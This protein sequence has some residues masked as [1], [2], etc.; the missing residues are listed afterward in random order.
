VSRTPERE[1]R[2]GVG[3]FLSRRPQH[4]WPEGVVHHGARLL[5]VVGLA[6]LVTLLFPPESRL[7]VAPYQV[8]M[9]SNE[10]VIARVPFAVP[11]SQAELARARRDARAAVPPTFNLRAEAADSTMARLDRFFERLDS[12]ATAADSAEAVRRILERASISPTEQQIELL[13]GE[14]GRQQLRGTAMQ[15]AREILPL[16]VAPAG[17]LE[18]LSTDRVTVRTADGEAEGE[19]SV[20]RDEV[21]SSQDFYVQAVNRLPD[22]SSPDLQDVLRVIMIQHIE[23]TYELNVPAT[24]LDRDQAAR[25][26]QT[27]SQ[28]VLEGEAIV[29]ANE[30]ITPET[31]ARL[32]AYQAQLRA[33]GL[34]ESRE[35]ARVGPMLGAGMLNLLLLSVFGLLLLFFRREVY[36]NAR[37]V[38]LITAL[39]ALYVVGAAVVARSG[40]PV[41]ALPIAFVA[42]AVAVLWDGRMALVLA[43]VL[44]VLSG[45]QP[46]LQGVPV[47]VTTMIGGS[48]AAL[49]VRAV[50]RRAQTWIFIAIITGA[51]ALAIFALALLEARVTGSIMT[52]L[53]AAAGNAVLS[54]IVAMGFLPVFEWM[55]GV[56]TDQTLLEWADPNRD[57]LKRLSMEAPGTYA[58]TINVANL[59]EA[60]ANAIGA[61]GLLCRVGLYYHDV[62]KMLKPHYFVEN[63]PDGRNPH[64]RLKP[65]TSAA[66]VKEH[67]TEG[68]RLA[69]E[70]KVPAVVAA[71]IPEHHGTQS[72]G[73]FLE[74]AKEE[75]GADQVDPEDFTYPGPK[76]RSKETAIAMLADSIESATR[77]LQDPTPER[78]RGL[79]TSIVETKIADGQLDDAPLTLRELAQMKEQF[80][81]VLSGVYHHRLDYPQTR[82]LT[83]SPRKD[84]P[85]P[86]GHG[87]VEHA[88]AAQEAAAHVGDPGATATPGPASGPDAGARSGEGEGR[89]AG[90]GAGRGDPSDRGRRG[91]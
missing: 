91:T 2:R 49:S 44:A 38:S 45:V 46:G 27:V 79:V 30:Q 54:A 7:R 20:P 17:D 13:V 40:W 67:V 48:A 4:A 82:H 52:A 15:A 72:I 68:Y 29:R 19:R 71:F 59:A 50:R 14:Q 75:Y 66:I 26:V 1:R 28:S 78:I 43:L 69:R 37:W 57:L 34:L 63:Q 32:E 62:G 22:G 76:P 42:L 25:A 58:H 39:V 85:D 84:E 51:Y 81:K 74:K 90:L 36:T 77:A 89:G 47:I 35:G 6:V 24:E 80:A 61:N 21:I 12:A 16:G 70:A 83:E 3:R 18:D 5:M 87:D 65:D 41:E 73:F 56:T 23:F 8:G 9:V 86:S 31:L 53:A 64:D 60:A 55:T 88:D 10:S 11:L 33:L